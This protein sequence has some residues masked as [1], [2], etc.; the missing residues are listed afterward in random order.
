MDDRLEGVQKMT[1]MWQVEMFFHQLL[2]FLVSKYLT[3]G[4]KRDSCEHK[5]GWMWWRELKKTS[6]VCLELNKKREEEK[7]RQKVI[8]KGDGES[9]W[10]ESGTGFY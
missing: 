4:N 9:E 7:S 10:A 8:L 6:H 1:L 5:P 2:R 3:A